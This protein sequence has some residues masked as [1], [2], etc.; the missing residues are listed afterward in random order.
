MH[1]WEKGLFVSYLEV[2]IIVQDGLW[3]R[4]MSIS[5]EEKALK[6]P[7]RC[8]ITK[9]AAAHHGLAGVDTTGRDRGRNERNGDDDD[10]DEQRASGAGDGTGVTKR[11]QVLPER[12]TD[13]DTGVTNNGSGP[14]DKRRDDRGG[15]GHQLL[16]SG[17]GPHLE[18]R[19]NGL[20]TLNDH[21]DP[22]DEPWPH[23]VQ[24]SSDGRWW[25]HPGSDGLFHA[26]TGDVVHEHHERAGELFTGGERW[27]FNQIRRSHC[28]NC[29]PKGPQP[30]YHPVYHGE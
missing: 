26:T 6:V 13:D 29:G 2:G 14:R 7:R 27:Q 19:E 24:Q 1:A 16:G 5:V 30:S 21:V 12:P 23:A 11:P 4:S 17:D 15:G 3:S 10:D 20:D 28:K 25:R 9:A 22:D 8:Q 18:R